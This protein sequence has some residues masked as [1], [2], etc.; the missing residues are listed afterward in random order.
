MG[1]R[2]L[3]S[4]LLLIVVLVG[5]SA[6][7]VYP[8][9][10]RLKPG[11]DLGGG[12]SLLFEIDD[13]GLDSSQRQDLAERVMNI[14]KK[15]VDPRGNRNLVWRPIGQ[16]RLEIQMPR[17][18]EGQEER[19]AQYEDARNQLVKNNITE[20]QLRA[21]L[22]M[23]SDEQKTALPHLVGQVASRKEMLQEL[24]TVD[25]QYEQM[26]E[27]GPPATQPTTA[28]SEQTLSRQEYF[29]K[30]D[31]LLQRRETLIDQLLAT[32]VDVNRLEDFLELEPQNEDR[33]E[34][35]S[36]IK[37]NHPELKKQIEGMIEAYDAYAEYKGVLDDPSD[38][39]RL[40]RGS[41]VL[42]FRIMVTRDPQDRTMIDADRPEY[43]ESIEKYVEQLKKYGPRP[44]GGDNFQ[45]FEVEDPKEDTWARDAFIVEEYAGKKYVLAH[46]TP[47][48]GLLQEE[49]WN[50]VS[51]GMIRDRRGMPAVSFELDTAG[52]I[53]FGEL[54]GNN[55]NRPLGI[56]LDG[57][58]YSAPNIQSKILTRGEITGNFSIQDVHYMI[59]TLEA[60][61]LPARL[62]D[63][64]LQQKSIGPTLGA[65]NRAQ[66]QK[67]IIVAFAATIAFMFI[68]YLYCGVIA[69]IALLMNLVITLGVMSFLQ[70]TF[71]LPGIAGL[72]LT[73]GMA[74]DANVLIYERIREELSRGIS[75][76][77]AVKLGYE[78]AFSAILDSNVTTIL[79]AVIL[80]SLG[81][82]EVKGFG[83]TLGIGLCTSMFTALFVTRQFF[84]V[85]VPNTLDSQETKRAW[86]MGG[87]LGLASG[88]FLGLG[89]LAGQGTDLTES[90]MYNFGIFLLWLFGT[91]AIMLIAMWIFRYVYYGMKHRKNNRM[92][93]L[94]LFSEPN[95]SWMSKYKAFWGISA[96]I[97][98]AGV[99]F[100]SRV[101]TEDYLDIEFLGGTAVQVQLADEVTDQ[102]QEQADKKIL[103][104]YVAGTDP[105]TMD[106]NKSVGWL[107]VA[108]DSIENAEVSP[109]GTNRFEIKPARELTYSQLQAL[110][111][112][113]KKVADLIES[114]GIV[115]TDQGAFVQ[116][117]SRAKDAIDSPDKVKNL[118][119]TAAEYARGAAD[120]LR[121]A[122]IQLIEQP[123]A[124]KSESKSFEIITTET[125]RTLVAEALLASMGDILQ[126]TQSIEADLTTDPQRA[127]DG[128]FPIPQGANNLAD[129]IGGTMQTSVADYKGGL[130][131]VFDN[132]NPAQPVSDIERRLKEMRFQSDFQ[133]MGW[134]VPKVIGL[135]LA[136]GSTSGQPRYRKITV[137]VKDPQYL[138]VQGEDNS[139]WEQVAQNELGLTQA[140]LASTR[141]LQRVTKF[142][143]QVAAEAT[144]KAVIAIILAMLAIAGY[145]WMRFGS[146]EFGLAGII[147][148]FHDVAITLTCVMACHHLYDTGIGKLLMLE[149]FKIDLAMIAAFLTIV[150][151][152]I[153]DSIVIFDRIRENRGRMATVSSPLIN[154]SINQTLS[155]TLITSFTTFLVVLVM[156]I[157]G[158]SGIH[159]FAFAMIIGS[160]TGTYSTIAI[161]S[162]MIQ[163]PRAMW[164]VSICAATL[165]A[166]VVISTITNETLQ[167]VL[168]IVVGVLALLGLAKQ[169]IGIVSAQGVR[170]PKAA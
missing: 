128:I 36:Q 117:K 11:I 156:Y 139:D 54:T 135:K 132:L 109:A 105:N 43:Q 95:I 157:Y 5:M 38:L 165:M 20:P 98:V 168:M 9:G 166:F 169:I 90:T 3:W 32:N 30:L 110:L 81:S 1:E 62:K 158:G 23:S 48:M 112:G 163:H 124:G 161:A 22:D 111:L 170:Q 49:N 114:D 2:N 68:Y 123:L 133:D 52:G 147:A 13:S 39:M 40:L 107:R 92:P 37:Q 59:N 162:P 83:L 17:P 34:G 141:S 4:K 89:Y 150:G 25:G 100:E 91:T 29:Q 70:A 154:K 155:R 15:R 159:G 145:L 14:L 16:N 146:V 106:P 87:I 118:L 56:F 31:D 58:A 88:A 129:V 113:S 151:Y 47:D 121:G 84:H 94:R 33:I 122:R 57:K 74:V 73:L 71:T 67:A 53:Q 120:R 160:I 102:F 61:A 149:D 116:F 42:E 41:G 76:R 108:A 144:Q 35:I 143:A 148:L 152:S 50:L 80:G 115:D 119:A 85:M 69:D 138:Y 142:E 140:A 46:S 6:W 104:Q 75:V 21:L 19:R 126:V 86:S 10:K 28:P 97:I 60:G 18:P 77:M 65:A 101:E 26:S 8:P 24:V 72:I 130:A 55:I 12:H 131:M 27:E 99:I 79:I 164:I 103:D 127:P 82:E 45:W 167:N 7:Q 51:A 64:P 93:M 134:R 96:L 44:R 125:S 136:E 66:G 137:L 78:K 63:V 153:N